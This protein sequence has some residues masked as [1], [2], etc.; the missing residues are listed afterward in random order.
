MILS[1]KTVEFVIL[2]KSIVFLRR[3]V[4]KKQNLTKIKLY[5]AYRIV[6][7]L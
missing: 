2:C 5:H 3:I 1:Q 7:W 4:F 6:V